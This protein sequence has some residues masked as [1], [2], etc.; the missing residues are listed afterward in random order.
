MHDLIRTPLPTG[1]ARL[2]AVTSSMTY[3]ITYESADLIHSECQ[4]SYWNLTETSELLPPYRIIANYRVI[5]HFE[6][7]FN[8]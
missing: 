5:T 8:L 4:T 3:A 1:L 7:N 2:Y 6:T